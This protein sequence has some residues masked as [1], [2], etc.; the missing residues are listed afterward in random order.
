MGAGACNEREQSGPEVES[1]RIL[2]AFSR[3]LLRLVA[4]FDAAGHIVVVALRLVGDLQRGTGFAAQ[5]L[6]GSIAADDN[7]PVAIL[8]GHILGFAFLRYRNGL[9]GRVDFCQ[10]SLERLFRCG[11]GWTLPRSRLRVRRRPIRIGSILRRIRIGSLPR[12]RR[13]RIAQRGNEQTRTKQHRDSS[14]H[15]KPLSVLFSDVGL[16]AR[17]LPKKRMR[18]FH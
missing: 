14:F 7:C 18:V 11:G 6:H 5:A 15:G 2:P 9:C 12:I 16:G 10:A 8:E 3:V 17:F 13:L 4:D 1:R